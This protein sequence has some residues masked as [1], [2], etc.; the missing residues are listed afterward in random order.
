VQGG[1]LN[2]GDYVLAGR[3]H[4]K[5]KAMNDERGQP[6]EQAGPSTPVSILGLDGAPQ[7]GDKF[8]SLKM[9]VKQNLSQRSEHNCSVS[10]L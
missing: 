5:V 7:A 1:T 8:M 6:V 4:G 2:I 9:S 10:N 3:T